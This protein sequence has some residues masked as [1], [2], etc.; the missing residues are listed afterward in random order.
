MAEAALY[1]VLLLNAI[2]YAMG[3]HAFYIRREVFGKVMVPVKED[4][5]NT[6]YRAIVESGRFMGGFNFA[7]SA[8]NIM[9]LLNIGGF[10]SDGQW[11]TLLI[12]NALAHGSQVAGNIPMAV[13]N[14][15]GG[16]ALAG[17][18][19]SDA[20]DL[21]DRL[22]ADGRK[23]WIGGFPTGLV[24]NRGAWIAHHNHADI[25]RLHHDFIVLIENLNAV[26]RQTDLRA[27]FAPAL[28][29][30]FGFDPQGVSRIDG[31]FPE[32]FVKAG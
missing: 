21:C 15:R 28:L 6:A 32:Q 12:F 19:G 13:Q 5:D 20:A 7:L 17:L 23:C 9:L 30:D 10:E 27:R 14:R 1:I 2:W 11:A 16:R 22:C 18:Q 24:V 25:D 8:L 29:D 4:R 31:L 26:L 3:F